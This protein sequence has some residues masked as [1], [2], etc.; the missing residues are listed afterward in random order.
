MTP[1]RKAILFAIAILLLAGVAAALDVPPP[2]S[3]WYTDQARLLDASSAGMLNAKLRTFEEQSGVQF[4]I[5][6]F[7]SLQG[8]AMEDFT[9]RCAERWKAGQK[10]YDNGLILFVFVKERKLRV[11][12]GYGL[13]PT[14][15]DAFAS[16]VIRNY[17]APKFKEGDYAGGLNAGAD[18]LIAK[19][20]GSE[21]PVPVEKR[22]AQP[23]RSSSRRSGGGVDPVFL[24]VIAAIFFFFI[25]PLL[26]R[27]G[28][29]GG[30][31]GCGGCWPLFIPWGG[32]GGGGTTFGG[33][34]FG[35]GGGGG[36]SGGG[37]GFGG[38]GASGGW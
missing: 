16:E 23:Q 38:G 7:P 14:I 31:G 25:L 29:R 35:G 32:F 8:E 1:L 30:C 28:R 22:T 4:L 6:V 17:I 37:G 13:E 20:R 18:A 3:Q 33:G 21:P 2:P 10:K 24:L 26:R 36:W 19:I 5:Y 15:T 9:I 11:E 34:G 12:V 27:G